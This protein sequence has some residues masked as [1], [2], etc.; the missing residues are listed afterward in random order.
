MATTCVLA[1][2]R[3]RPAALISMPMKEIQGMGTPSFDTMNGYRTSCSKRFQTLP[4]TRRA[5]GV[6]RRRRSYEKDLEGVLNRS[7][8]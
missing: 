1:V 5:L 4:A 8:R 7:C 6:R 3:T 2:I